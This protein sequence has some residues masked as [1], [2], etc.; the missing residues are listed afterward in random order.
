M[1]KLA[2]AQVG[3]AV[4]NGADDT[5]EAGASAKN[6]HTRRTCEELVGHEL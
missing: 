4:T 3:K 2:Y 5:V 6:P 1:K